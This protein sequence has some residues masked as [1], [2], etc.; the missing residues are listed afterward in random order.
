[1]NQKSGFPSVP[2]ETLPFCCGDR[3]L[4]I[5]SSDLYEDNLI[6]VKNLKY[7][8][9]SQMADM[10]EDLWNEDTANESIAMNIR[11]LYF[12]SLETLM[13]FLSAFAQA[14]PIV[15][16]WMHL[17][18]PND[19]SLIIQK[20]SNGEHS[21]NRTPFKE[22]TW[23]KLASWIIGRSEYKEKF[24]DVYGKLWGKF[25]SD[26]LDNSLIN[27][28]NS[29]KHGLRISLQEDMKPGKIY[30]ISQNTSFDVGPQGLG[31]LSFVKRKIAGFNHNLCRQVREWNILDNLEGLRLVSVSLEQVLV[32][33]TG[34]LEHMMKRSG[35]SMGTFT[36][37]EKRIYEYL[38][39]RHED[40]FVFTEEIQGSTSPLRK[41]DVI[42][43]YRG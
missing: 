43:T 36:I 31:A 39:N 20:I 12:Q 10:L 4:A 15:V 38:A 5:S 28:Y 9:Y 29:Q 13:A 34:Y 1:M 22:L 17:Y 18:M 6:Y 42:S 3:E 7:D 41:G 35:I 33:I 25:S 30:N 27:E 19:L 11:L 16:G 2:I 14:G 24:E 40:T 23:F 21:Y 26:F 8:Y 32:C 37:P